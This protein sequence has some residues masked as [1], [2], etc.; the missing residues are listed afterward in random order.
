[1]IPGTIESSLIRAPEP[2]PVRKAVPK[3]ITH[4]NHKRVNDNG[5]KPVSFGVTF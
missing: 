5:L 2:V 1:M 4:S 3:F